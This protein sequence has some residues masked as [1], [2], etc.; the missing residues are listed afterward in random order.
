MNN[1]ELCKFVT[2]SGAETAFFIFHEARSKCSLFS[3]PMSML[4]VL[5]QST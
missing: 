4:A 2:F 3:K 1:I 5:K